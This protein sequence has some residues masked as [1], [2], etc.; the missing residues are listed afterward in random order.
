MQ[1]YTSIERLIRESL[2]NYQ[3]SINQTTL[4]VSRVPIIPLI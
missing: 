2:V 4:S 1:D 3:E